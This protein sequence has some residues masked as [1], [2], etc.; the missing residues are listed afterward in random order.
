VLSR[1]PSWNKGDLLLREGEGCREGKKEGRV[2]ERGIERGWK[3]RKGSGR[4]GQKERG[5]EGRKKR[6]RR[7][8]EGEEERCGKGGDSPYQS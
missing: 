6:G 7:E 1:P 2:G 5:G 4:E 8:E 3:G